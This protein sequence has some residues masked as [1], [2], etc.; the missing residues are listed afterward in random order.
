MWLDTS[1]TSRVALAWGVLMEIQ[2]LKP[3]DSGRPYMPA[4]QNHTTTCFN[5]ASSAQN[6]F[7]IMLMWQAIALP[8]KEQRPPKLFLQLQQI[9][10]VIFEHGVSMHAFDLRVFK[11]RSYICCH[12]C[13][14]ADSLYC[15]MSSANTFHWEAML[16]SHLGATEP[17][18]GLVAARR[19]CT[20]LLPAQSCLSRCHIPQG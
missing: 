8:E 12:D 16:R 7:Y 1:Q 4:Q 3:H 6:S 14:K 5:L 9:S 20:W 19:C 2:G 11:L 18:Q 17:D 10:F 15:S 13:S